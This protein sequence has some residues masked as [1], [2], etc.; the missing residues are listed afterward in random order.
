M[1]KQTSSSFPPSFA[2]NRLRAL[3]LRDVVFVLF[4]LSISHLLVSFP[5]FF[6][7]LLS[8]RTFYFLNI[9]HSRTSILGNVESEI[10]CTAVIFHVFV[11]VEIGLF[12]HR[13]DLYVFTS[14]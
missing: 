2:D 1:E 12:V 7:I 9:H 14:F 4:C 11:C 13:F 8:S 3:G 10:G 6:F 5:I